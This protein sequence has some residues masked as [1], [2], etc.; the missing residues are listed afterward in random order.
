MHCVSCLRI[1]NVKTYESEK[2]ANEFG[3]FYAS[4]GSN[5]AKLIGQPKKQC[6]DYLNDMTSCNIIMFQSPCTNSEVKN[7]IGKLLNKTSHGY[8][9]ISNKLLK[10]LSQVVIHPLTYLFNLS[11]EKGIF[12][13]LYKRADVVPLYKSK[14][15]LDCV[16]YRPISLL[17]T[18]S[19][20][21]EK[22]IYKRLYLFLTSKT[23]Q[24]Y[25]SQYG[26]RSGHSCEN[27]ISEL[28]SEIV[29]AKSEG[30]YTVSVFLDLSKAFNTL[31][32]NLLLNK[33]EKYGVRGIGLQWFTSYLENRK[34]RSKVHVENDEN[35]YYSQYCD[36]SYGTP[37]GSCLGSLLFLVYTND[38]YMHLKL[39]N[40]ILFADDTTIY[41]SHRNLNYLLFCLKTDLDI[42]TDWFKANELTLNLSKSECMIFK[43]N[44]RNHG[45][46]LPLVVSGHNLPIVKETKFLGV[47]I[48]DNLNWQKHTSVLLSKLK[49]NLNLLK[50]GKNLL[51]TSC[52]KILYHT[53][54][55]SHINYGLVLW[56]A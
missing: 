10:E 45:K 16:N 43:P 52:K 51:S 34:L 7:L 13:E 44:Q 6:T 9:G 33:L 50:T 2:I 27:A 46:M 38:I 18:V 25:I 55:C 20:L 14:S 40:C 1:N 21:L 4:L 23:N 56:A 24:L 35:P 54:I 53:Q 29:K 47:W 48:D 26:F 37:Q 42:I 11:L 36:I 19:K 32:H 49:K 8:D 39:T 15:K 28:V 17:P 30:L 3:K 5:Y 31:N 12:P 41:K 22:I